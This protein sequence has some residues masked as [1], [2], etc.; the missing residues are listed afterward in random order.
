M[1]RRHFAYPFL[2]PVKDPWFN[3]SEPYNL[4]VYW[5]R[6]PVGTEFY[7]KTIIESNILT[8]TS[9]ALTS[10]VSTTV[11]HP[12][13]TVLGCASASEMCRGTS[14]TNRLCVNITSNGRPHGITPISQVLGL[15]ERQLQIE[16]RLRAAYLYGNFKNIVHSAG[17][18]GLLAAKYLSGAM[19][20]DAPIPSGRWN[21]Q[22]ESFTIIQES[23]PTTWNMH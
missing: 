12:Y 19:G 3:N 8:T 5:G 6:N 10:M 2:A 20:A 11:R 22:S 4:T 16:N 13:T 9:R 14:D 17:S 1:H 18:P 15:S 23:I 7:G 21:N